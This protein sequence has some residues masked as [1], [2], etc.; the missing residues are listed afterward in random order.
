MNAPERHDVDEVAITGV[1]EQLA[2]IQPQA[3]RR[4]EQPLRS[5]FA[6]RATARKGLEVAAGFAIAD[7][8]GSIR[9]TQGQAIGRNGYMLIVWLGSRWLQMEAPTNTAI[10]FS[11]YRML[12]D[13]GWGDAGKPARQALK[14]TLLA[15]QEARWQGEVNDAVTGKK[16]HEDHFGIID[17]VLWPVTNN[18]RL[19][20]PGL[21]FLGSW[22]LEQLQNEAGV[23]LDWGSFRELPPI[24][25]KF[26]GLLEN[27]RFVQRDGEMEWQAYALAAPLFA[28]LGSTCARDR[29]N[30]AA[31]MRACEAISQ[32]D[33][34]YRFTRERVLD[35]RAGWINQ[36]VVARRPR[37]KTPRQKARLSPPANASTTG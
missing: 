26:Y 18:G 1:Q 6:D 20:R 25:R 30:V 14:R 8:L 7:R 22:F 17:R 34:T 35:A 27:E 10:P 2:L 36:V 28:T 15:L 32:V 16:T 13:F 31:V 5:G 12:Q 33:P 19:E 9:Q 23:W 11:Q 3:M 21:I 37:P 4:L 29:D 24:A